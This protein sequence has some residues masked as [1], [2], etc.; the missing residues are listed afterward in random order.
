MNVELIMGIGQ[1]AIRTTV[2]LAAPMLGFGLAVGLIMGLLQAVTQIH[3]MTLVMI[4]KMGA[5]VL[6]LVF[7]S[8]WMIK[9]LVDFTTNL[10]NNIPMYIR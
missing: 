1:E 3:E 6:A 10:I 4:P 8:P 2:L 9:L 5:V 7:F